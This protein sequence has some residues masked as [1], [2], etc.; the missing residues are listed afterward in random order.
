MRAGDIILTPL[1]QADGVIKNRP[2]LFSAVYAAIWRSA[3]VWNQ[4]AVAPVD[5]RL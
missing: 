2:A 1:P 5:T 4:H 3:C